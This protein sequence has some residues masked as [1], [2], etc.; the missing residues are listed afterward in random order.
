MAGSFLFYI[1]IMDIREGTDRM[2]SSDDFRQERRNVRMK[3]DWLDPKIYKPKEHTQ[4][5][6]KSI[7]DGIKYYHIAYWDGKYW[8][9]D[10]D[11]LM[12]SEYI[13]GWMN[14]PE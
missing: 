12:Y 7:V 4:V 9:T 14:I 10:A 11:D 1:P 5:L 8:S 6:T 2:L 3:G 13:V